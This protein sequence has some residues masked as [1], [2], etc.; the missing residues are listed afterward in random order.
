VGEVY[1]AKMTHKLATGCMHT[2]STPMHQQ[3]IDDWNANH[4]HAMRLLG[5]NTIQYNTMQYNT[6]AAQVVVTSHAMHN[7]LD[8]VHQRLVDSVVHSLVDMLDV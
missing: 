1:T 2:P 4:S 8:R 3:T 5:Y 7:S 6:M